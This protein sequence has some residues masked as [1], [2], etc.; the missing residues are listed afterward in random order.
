MDSPDTAQLAWPDPTGRL[1]TIVAGSAPLIVGACSGFLARDGIRTWYRTI[2]RPAWDP[3]NG[4]FGPVWTALY[5]TMG[6]ALVKVLHADEDGT[7]RPVGLA[8]F[9]LQLVLNGAWSW[10]FFVRHDLRGALLE[11]VALWLS[12]LAT[13]LAFYRTRPGA[14]LLFVPYLAWVSFATVLTAE[15][16]RLNR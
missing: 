10:I 4:V 12:V 16:W 2:R 9:S 7:A 11:S 14:G 15:I 5:A 3:P 8:L 6:V 13:L 1:V